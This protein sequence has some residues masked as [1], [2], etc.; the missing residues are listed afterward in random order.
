MFGTN[1]RELSIKKSTKGYLEER[2]L[3]QE[4]RYIWR[5]NKFRVKVEETTPKRKSSVLCLSRDAQKQNIKGTSVYC[6]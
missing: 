1:K 6:G 2:N 4:A 5:A 3:K